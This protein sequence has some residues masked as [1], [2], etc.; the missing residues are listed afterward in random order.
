MS[1]KVNQKMSSHDRE[2]AD[3]LIMDLPDPETVGNKFL[4]LT[5][6]LVCGNVLEQFQRNRDSWTSPTFSGVWDA[7]QCP[8]SPV[9]PALPLFCLLPGA[10]FK[11]WELSLS[12][13]F[14][15]GRLSFADTASYCFPTPGNLVERTVCAGSAHSLWVTRTLLL[16]LLP[17]PHAVIWLPLL[18]LLRDYQHHH[19][20]PGNSQNEHQLILPYLT[21]LKVFKKQFFWKFILSY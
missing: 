2:P 13:Q 16:C 10:I 15:A 14:S 5:S 1:M 12:Q 6:H 19:Q 4:L 18:S 9:T 11:C 20:L 17:T 7:L 21:T 8:H 3:A